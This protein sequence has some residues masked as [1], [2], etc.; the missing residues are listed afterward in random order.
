MCVCFG[1]PPPTHPLTHTHALTHA[2]AH[3][4]TLTISNH[5]QAIP[6]RTAARL[7]PTGFQLFP[8]PA[9]Q[10]NMIYERLALDK[11]KSK[12]DKLEVENRRFLQEK[13]ARDADLER[14]IQ[15]IDARPGTKTFKVHRCV[16]CV[17]VDADVCV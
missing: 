12:E 4:R 3:S 17:W 2:H 14:L 7:Q 10:L 15:E 16:G 11:A 1:S 13:A 8:L 6:D 5:I 9:N